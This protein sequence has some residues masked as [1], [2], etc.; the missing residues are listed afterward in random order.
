MNQTIDGE[1]RPRSFPALAFV[2]LQYLLPKYWL[3]SVIY[4]LSRIQRQAVKNFL[5]RKFVRLY[6][7]NVDEAE[8]FVPDGYASF[9]DFFTRSLSNDCRPISPS[10]S[11]IVSPVDGTV[12]AAGKINGDQIFQAKGRTY[13]L[14]D[15]LL[16]NL[17]EANQYIDGLF[18]TV[19]LA[20][21]NYHRV[22]APLAGELTAMRYVPG[23]LFSVNAMTV[24]RL[25]R[26]FTRNERL[27]CHFRTA[28]GPM[29]LI[30]VGALNVG[31]ITTP[32]TGQIRP[33]KRGVVEEL[34]LPRLVSRHVDKG[35]LLGW[36]N[37][38]S[39]VILL[40]PPGSCSW[41]DQ[42]NAGRKL[43]MGEAIGEQSISR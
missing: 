15:L 6:H 25:P 5:I 7:V 13:R 39:T 20:P 37:M 31:S 29:V 30:F 17:D 27:I 19:Y 35:E 16:T 8:K 40:L 3:T 36:F 32:W 24:S 10:D 11:T 26:L 41:S 12:S 28:A 2:V 42:L 9:N 4:S 43:L 38:G 34:S 1:S 14:Q 22:H 33:K 23:A 21:C 18:A